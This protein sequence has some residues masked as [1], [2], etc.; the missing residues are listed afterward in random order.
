[1]T[2]RVKYRVGEDL[3][4]VEFDIWDPRYDDYV[5]YIDGEKSYADVAVYMYIY[6]GNV[7]DLVY[8]IYL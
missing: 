2:T 6:N 3:E 8:Y 7:V 5:L 4:Y 1:M